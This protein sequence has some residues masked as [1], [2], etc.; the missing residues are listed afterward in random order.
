VKKPALERPALTELVAYVAEERCFRAVDASQLRR[1]RLGL[2][3]HLSARDGGADLRG[4]DRR[5]A[6]IAIVEHQARADTATRNPTGCVTPWG[7]IGTAR[8]LP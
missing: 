8:T 5:E 7:V 1:A 3:E 2:F 4:D 6:S